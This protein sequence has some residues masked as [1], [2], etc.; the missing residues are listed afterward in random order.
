MKKIAVLAVIVSALLLTSCGGYSHWFTGQWCKE[1]STEAK[2][3]K[4]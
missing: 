3:T 4:S 2:K 1:N